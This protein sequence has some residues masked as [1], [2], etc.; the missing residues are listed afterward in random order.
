MT[1]LRTYLLTHEAAR[2]LLSVAGRRT[3]ERRG[4]WSGGQAERRYSWMTAMGLSA[5]D[6]GE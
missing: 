3:A 6:V 2:G 5:S 4:V 1:D